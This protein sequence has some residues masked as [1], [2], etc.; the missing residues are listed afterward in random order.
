MAK[1]EDVR[2]AAISKARRSKRSVPTDTVDYEK[3]VRSDAAKFDPNVDMEIVN[4]N[5]GAL[6]KKQGSSPS[7]Q[8]KPERTKLERFRQV[9]ER[10]GK[11]DKRRE[12][13]HDQYYSAAFEKSSLVNYKPDKAFNRALDEAYEESKRQFQKDFGADVTYN[14][15]QAKRIYKAYQTMDDEADID[16]VVSPLLESL[17]SGSY[18]R[19]KREDN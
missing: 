13:L 10:F 15:A 1:K 19:R 7:P 16:R 17:R 6:K 18:F 11:I 14:P 4:P 8:S 5:L 3:W 12:E 2:R 9:A